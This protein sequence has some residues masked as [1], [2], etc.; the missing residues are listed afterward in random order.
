MGKVVK[1]NGYLESNHR[2]CWLMIK[3]SINVFHFLNIT[4]CKKSS[5][6]IET[7][8]INLQFAALR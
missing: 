6:I 7:T 5:A 3:H 2:S 1:D 4:D 8:L